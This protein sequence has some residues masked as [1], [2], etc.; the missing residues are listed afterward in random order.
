MKTPFSFIIGVD[1]RRR[2]HLVWLD[3]SG[4]RAEEASRRVCLPRLVRAPLGNSRFRAAPRNQPSRSLAQLSRYGREFRCL[5]PPRRGI[6][7]RG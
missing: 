6:C 4:A 1:R 3:L 5:E 2:H 7:G